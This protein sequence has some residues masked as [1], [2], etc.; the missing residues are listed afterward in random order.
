MGLS[1]YQLEGNLAQEV[2]RKRENHGDVWHH[3]LVDLR[4]TVK[5]HVSKRNISPKM[6]IYSTALICVL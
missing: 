4:P 3:A 2:W 6:I 5:F 1:V